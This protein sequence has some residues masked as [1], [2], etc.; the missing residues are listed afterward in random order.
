MSIGEM[1]KIEEMI[2]FYRISG[3]TDVKELVRLGS[4]IKL[5]S[6]GHIYYYSA[7]IIPY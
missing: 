1:Y 5:S 4:Q 3:V 7:A 6:S 2:H